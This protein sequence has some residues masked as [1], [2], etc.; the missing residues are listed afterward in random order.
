[1]G[2]P[3]SKKLS[4]FI[5]VYNEA[6]TVRVLL[7]K[8]RA[9]DLTSLGLE[10]ELIVIDDGSTDATRAEVAAFVQAHP[11]VAVYVVELT[12]NHG[13]GYAV[14]RGLEVA[15]GQWCVIQDADL[16]YD[17]ADWPSLL[18]PLVTGQSQVVF[19]NRSLPLGADGRRRRLYQV[20]LTIT[21]LV[22]FLLYR[23]EL[24]DV[25]TC[26]KAM[27]TELLRRLE[28]E[29]PRFAFDVEIACK[30]VGRGV[31]IVERPISYRPRYKAEGKKIRY[32]DFFSSVWAAL[33]YRFF[34]SGKARF[35]L[36]PAP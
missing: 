27:S 33:Y 11:D 5:P 25:A 7:E 28:P 10:R 13:K 16:E 24:T 20:G 35:R 23:H 22:I 15:T 30:L 18:K 1:M 9:V 3:P 4:I 17:P 6:P 2:S 21:Q 14:R 26:Y 36:P 34:D 32:R 29:Q 8:V 12:A 31:P 19:G